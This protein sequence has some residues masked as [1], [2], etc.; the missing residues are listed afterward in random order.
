M[1]VCICNAYRDAEIRE[2]ART[3]VRSA[4][5]A[6]AALGG[7]PRCGRCLPDAQDLIDREHG[8]PAVHAVSGREPVQAG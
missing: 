6:Y 5:K 2:A 8:A 3:G 1:Y 4:H 7:G